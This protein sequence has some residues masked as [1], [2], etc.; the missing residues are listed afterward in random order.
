MFGSLP[1]VFQEE[2]CD[3][4]SR[5]PIP[6]LGVEMEGMDVTRDERT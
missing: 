3:E 1:P 5:E 4:V 2:M 6:D